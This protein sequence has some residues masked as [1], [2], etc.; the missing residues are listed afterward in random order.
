M[1]LNDLNETKQ[2]KIAQRA[3]K[4]HYSLDYNLDSLDYISTR[5]MLYRVRNLLKEARTSK[6]LH[7][8]HQNSSYLKMIML[9]QMLSDHYHDLKI[10]RSVMFENEQVEKSQVILAAQDMI[11]SVQKMI[12]Q[13]SKMNAEEL[14]AVVDGISNEIGTNES[15]QFNSSVS[16]A[17]TQLLAGLAQSKG[18]LTQAIGVITGQSA[19][20]MTASADNL[21]DNMNTE[22]QAELPPPDEESASELEM[23]QEPEEEMGGAGRERR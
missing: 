16:Q 14:P 11:D 13:V 20:D 10:Q 15:E 7:E 6:N 23:P 5:D 1:K 8:S 4:E 9:E 22:P 12:E 3:L 2:K 21:D 19:P 18:A 17:L